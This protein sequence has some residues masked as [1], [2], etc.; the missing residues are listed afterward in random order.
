[1]AVLTRAGI[2]K[3]LSVFP[4]YFEGFLLSCKNALQ[5]E[6]YKANLGSEASLCFFILFKTLAL[7]CV[8][9]YTFHNEERSVS[10]GEHGCQNDDGSNV[11]SS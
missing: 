2:V 4:L 9:L 1:M 10:L 8:C 11:V 3:C 5:D 6:V 7:F